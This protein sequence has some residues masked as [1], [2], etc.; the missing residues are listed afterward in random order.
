MEADGPTPNASSALPAKAAPLPDGSV[1]GMEKLGGVPPGPAPPPRLLGTFEVGLPIPGTPKWTDVVAEMDAREP[2]TTPGQEKLLGAQNKLGSARAGMLPGQATLGETAMLAIPPVA[3]AAGSAAVA[4]GSAAARQGFAAVDAALSAYFTAQS[5]KGA[6]EGVLAAKKAYEQGDYGEMV[7]NLGAAGIEGAFGYWAGRNAKNRFQEVADIAKMKRVLQERVN[8]EAAAKSAPKQIAGPETPP[9]PGF[10]PDPPP[11]FVPEV[12]AIRGGPLTAKGK[13]RRS[14]LQGEVKQPVQPPAVVPVPEAQPPAVAPEPVVSS[15]TSA[16]EVE[17]VVA[18]PVEEMPQFASVAPVGPVAP[19][20][21]QQSPVVAEPPAVPAEQSPVLP[22]NPPAVPEEVR[23]TGQRVPPMV[24]ERLGNLEEKR[25]ALYGRAAESPDGLLSPE[26]NAALGKLNERID[27]I[28]TEYD[29]AP[30]AENPLEP[31]ELVAAARGAG[32]PVKA[33][34]VTE[35]IAPERKPQRVATPV[36]S[37]SPKALKSAGAILREMGDR[38][39]WERTGQKYKSFPDNLA[40]DIADLMDQGKWELG[41]VDTQAAFE[42]IAKAAGKSMEELDRL[43]QYSGLRNAQYDAFK[44]AYEGRL[45]SAP[46]PAGPL[47]SG[48]ASNAVAPNPLKLAAAKSALKVAERKGKL[49]KGMKPASRYTPAEME[50]EDAA[51]PVKVNPLKAARKKA[52]T[53]E[54]TLGGSELTARDVDLLTKLREAKPGKPG[55]FFADPVVDAGLTRKEYLDLKRRELVDSTTN[56]PTIKA[57]IHMER[58][59]GRDPWRGT[60]LPGSTSDPEAKPLQS[61]RIEGPSFRANMPRSA[62]VQESQIQP[63]RAGKERYPVLQVNAQAMDLLHEALGIQGGYDI[64]G[65]TFT[66]PQ[67]EKVLQHVNTELRKA[68]LKGQKDQVAKWSEVRDAVEANRAAAKGG[69]MA[70]VQNGADITPEESAKALQ[71]ELDHVDQL[72]ATGDFYANH[73]GPEGLRTFLE[74]PAGAKAAEAVRRTYSDASDSQVAMEIGVRLMRPGRYRELNLTPEEAQDLQDAYVG[75]LITR[76]GVE[77]T[78]RISDKISTAKEKDSKVLYGNQAPLSSRRGAGLEGTPQTAEGARRDSGGSGGGDRS[79]PPVSEGPLQAKRDEGPEFRKRPNAL[80]TVADFFKPVETRIRQEG[81]AGAELRRKL[82][83]SRDIGEVQAGKRVVRLRESGLPQLSR[84]E[85]QNLVDSL[86]GFATPQN[87]AVQKVFETARQLTDE[88]AREATESGV[89]VKVKRTIRPGEELPEGAKLTRRQDEKIAAGEK[90]AITYQRPFRGR[91]N[92]YPH[93]IPSTDALQ[94]GDVRRDVVENMV[95]N[96]VVED[97][98]EASV[99]VDEYRRFVEEGGRTEKLEKFL[100]DSGQARD[101]DE[102]H[103]L[104]NRFRKRAIK[105]QGSLEYSRTADLPLYDP[106]PARILPKFITASSMRLAQVREFGQNNEQINRLIRVIDQTTG[107]PGFARSAVDRILGIV[108]EGDNAAARIS[109]AV[110]AFNGF[111][112]GLSFIPNATQGALNSLLKSDL[113]STVAGARGVFSREGRR[114]AM[115]SGASLE[116]VVNEMLR[117]VGSENSALGS[118]LKATGF[119][120]TEQTNRIFAA[121][122]GYAYA[123]RMLAKLQKNP[124]DGRARKVLSELGL[125]PDVLLKIGK[126]DGDAALI[127]AKKF[128]DITQFRGGPE[129]LPY[130]A[131]TPLGK[132]AFQFKSYIY[133]QTRL[134]YNETVGELRAGRPGRAFRTML[135]LAT[136]FPLAGEVVSD[137]RT[138]LKGGERKT[139]GIKRWLEDIGQAGSLGV[140]FEIINAGSNRR[141]VEFVAGPTAGEIGQAIDIAGAGDKQKAAAK[142]IVKHVPFLGPLFYNRVFPPKTGASPEMRKLQPRK[143]R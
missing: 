113:P 97:A 91:Q 120:A 50:P 96:R 26:E 85:R 53:G 14:A 122:A 107:N 93:I 22:V 28:V 73:L 56:K 99:F 55:A 89:M 31:G 119:T 3:E 116:G 111:K 76:H 79:V 84:E 36:V 115:Q 1:P 137:L 65:V 138:W 140:L 131:S 57:W 92:F 35:Q 58:A 60:G 29:L 67:A 61:R 108:N 23:G 30:K 114:F 24:L 18:P 15:E 100:V 118:F 101:V 71:E 95:R 143:L 75:A 83:R 54:P 2:V 86:Q 52:K 66:V 105:R 133:G 17:P 64:P 8:A 78:I 13:V 130:F 126:L 34:G 12:S 44:A 5:L 4:S 11:G 42:R 37:A 121:N 49:V 81:P 70:V 62:K 69:P 88:I 21:M 103:M 72:K 127:A 7:R 20:E 139:S 27:E 16:P 142:W 74:S 87:E 41:P 51:P 141:G 39:P 136:V 94:S 82:L 25:S 9:P 48:A 123:K 59:A 106:D 46:T 19:V 117:S 124:Q 43:D 125:K 80:R 40:H 68:R 109:R 104:L 98:G 47:D 10:V 63:V 135:L 134:I 38:S 132:V 32:I 90:I 110:R 112:L 102:A 77:R 6:G 129:D 45:S 33:H 128:S